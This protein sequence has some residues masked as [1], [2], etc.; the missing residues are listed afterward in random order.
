MEVPKMASLVIKALV[1][2]M[3]LMTQAHAVPFLSRELSS[4]ATTCNGDSNLCG[5]KYSNVTF[6]GAHG[7]YF[8][9]SCS[10]LLTGIMLHRFIR[11]SFSWNHP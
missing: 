11:H 9:L 6:A 8:L 4:R 1:A 5:R 3:L 2:V 7:Q 10:I